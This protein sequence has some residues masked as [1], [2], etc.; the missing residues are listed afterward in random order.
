MAKE[1]FVYEGEEVEKT[2]R[3]ASKTISVMP[4]KT[5]VETLVEITP[6]GSDPISGWKKWVAEKALF[7]VDA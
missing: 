1:T 4:N 5:R 7:K 2:G 3:T 6:V